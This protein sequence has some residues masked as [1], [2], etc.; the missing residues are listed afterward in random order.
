MKRP[1]NIFLLLLLLA[2]LGLNWVIWRD[3]S[4]RNSEVLADMLNSPAY[5]SQA[6][7]TAVRGGNASLE[8][9]RGTIAR[10]FLPVRYDA[11]PEAA[12]QA[13]MKLTSPV[14][15]GD[16]KALDRG[17]LIFGNFCA[18]CHGLSGLGDGTVTKRGFPP[19]PSLFAENAANMDD[20]QMFHIVTYGQA[21]MPGYAAQVS[22]ADRW[23]VIL[24]I[25]SL[26]K[27]QNEALR[28][29]SLPIPAITSQAPQEVRK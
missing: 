24:Y 28:S 21:I 15:P 29:A 26:Q 9:V 16:M 2:V 22:R 11:A 20:G 12:K 3:P 1:L 8:P 18:V 19:P 17:A 4:Q 5:K 10:G 6:E 25:R 13:G 7:N 14:A 27:K 23:D